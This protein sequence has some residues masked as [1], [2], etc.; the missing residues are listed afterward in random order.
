MIGHPHRDDIGHLV[1]TGDNIHLSL[2]GIGLDNHHNL[3]IRKHAMNLYSCNGGNFTGN[4]FG[5]AVYTRYNH[6]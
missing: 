4:S 6:T 5:P 3:A 2:N 1:Q